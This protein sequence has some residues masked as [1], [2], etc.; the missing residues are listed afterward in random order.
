[1]S[2]LGQRGDGVVEGR[3]VG[4][5]VP[6]LRGELIH[7]E[8]A[9]AVL[10]PERRREHE[11]AVRRLR[12]VLRRDRD[13]HDPHRNAEAE[14]AL[15]DA[16]QRLG[17]LA[18]VVLQEVHPRLPEVE[19][20]PRPRMDGVGRE[21]RVGA[22]PRHGFLERGGHHPFFDVTLEV[23]A[24]RVRRWVRAFELRALEQLAG[25][26]VAYAE[27]VRVD[28]D[29]QVD[30]ERTRALHLHSSAPLRQT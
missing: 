23:G 19:H 10:L 30:V 4:L 16:A 27:C 6:E 5:T 15:R 22:R 18:L 11:V 1:M 9:G 7:R 13:P 3:G 17:G 29:P 2:A 14:G 12:D 25:A 28:L 21:E 8:R 24:A 26:Q 20:Q